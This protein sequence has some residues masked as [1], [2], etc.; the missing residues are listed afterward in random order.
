[1]E[2]LWHINKLEE[3]LKQEEDHR[4]QEMAKIKGR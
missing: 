2:R 1:M 4:K 3:Q